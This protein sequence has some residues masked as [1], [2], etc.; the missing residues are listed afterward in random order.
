[1]GDVRDIQFLGL[2]SFFC[3][4]FFPFS[5]KLKDLKG[6]R[7]LTPLSGSLLSG[8]RG[9]ILY[10]FSDWLRIMTRN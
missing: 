10:S 2:A 3:D 8:N 4:N 6:E 5:K 7:E 1:M 9:L